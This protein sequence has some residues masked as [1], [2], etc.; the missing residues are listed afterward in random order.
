MPKDLFY[1]VHVQH[2]R[3]IPARV[4]CLKMLKMCTG[5]SISKFCGM[6]LLLKIVATPG[7]PWEQPQLGPHIAIYAWFYLMETQ[8]QIGYK[9][10]P[11]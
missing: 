11:F 3:Y 8:L 2:I 4:V 10:H 7:L 6:L 9:L 1:K 5:E